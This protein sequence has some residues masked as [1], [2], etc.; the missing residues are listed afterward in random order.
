M[1]SEEHRLQE[2][3]KPETPWK[4]WGPYLSERQWGTVRE[5]YSETGDAWNYFS[6]DQAR[7]RAYRWGEDG[8]A[9]I[10]DDRQR[11]C[12]ALALWNGADPIIKERLFGL[13]N[14]EGNHGED[15]KEYYFYLDS[16]PTHSYMKYLYK[17]PQ[18]AYPYDDLVQT[19]RR[20]GRHEPEYELLDTGVFDDNR[21]FDVLVEYAKATPEDIL[22][23]LSVTNRGAEAAP[24]HLLP[25]LWFRNTWSWTADAPRPSL[26]Q[27]DGPAGVSAV[28]AS[29]T[30]GREYSF[31]CEGSVPLLF[32]ENETNTERIFH[33]A[34]RTP[35][36]KDAIDTYIVHG[37]REAVNPARTGTKVA[38]HYALTVEAG[39]TAVVRLRLTASAAAAS[40]KR[41]WP[42][43]RRDVPRARAGGGRLLR[44]HHPGHGERRRGPGHATGPGRDAVVEA[45][46]QLR[47]RRVAARAG[48]R[49]QQPAAVRDPQR[50]LGPHGQRGRHLHARQ[51]GVPV[52]RGVGP[53]LPYRRPGPRGSPLR[54]AA[55]PPHARSAVPPPERPDPRV[56]V[57]L[58]RR[59]SPRARVGRL[60]HLPPGEGP[61]RQGRPRLPP[62]GL[63]E[64]RHQLHL[65]GEPEGSER[66]QRLPGGLPRPRQHRRLRPQRTAAHRGDAGAG[67]R[68]RLDGL[69]LPVH[70]PDL[71]GAGPRR[72]GLPGPDPQVLRALPVDRLRHG[73]RRPPGRRAVGRGGRLLLRRPPPPQ[74]PRRPPE[75]PIDGGPALAVRVDRLSRRSGGALPGRSSPGPGPSWRA[76]PTWR[77][78]SRRPPAAAYKQPPPPRPAQRGQAAPGAGAHARRER[79]PEPLRHPRALAVPPRASVR[80]LRRPRGLPGRLRAG[81]VDERAV[82]RQL[83]LAGP[84]LVPGEHPAA[85]RARQ[86]LRVLRR[87]LHRGVPDR[88]GP[89]DEP[90]RGHAGA[91]APADPDLP[92]RRAG[93]PPGSRQRPQ[94]PG[95]SPLARPDPVLRVLPRRQR[96]RPRGQPPDGLDGA[97]RPRHSP[98]RL[99]GRPDAPRPLR[100]LGAGPAAAARREPAR[101]RRA[102][103]RKA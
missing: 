47:R 29:D 83:Q 78:T 82:R 59:E 101:A 80:L 45:V 37:R 51:V 97:G 28:V 8:L 43:L 66:A 84:D 76:T 32:T 90:L 23:R 19:N 24:L 64:A 92:A 1:A 81:R 77:P 16:T 49:S 79:V 34:N 85:A 93:R 35:Y 53:R 38:A 62:A 11:L 41:L 3:T 75:S 68:H 61:A 72:P 17:Y 36:V 56:R 100:P 15:V 6:H 55:A 71:V 30:E 20:R 9:G 27:L 4:K 7:S 86:P 33:T 54:Q 95:R 21:Y 73:P 102:P 44:G 96:R 91:G 98:P 58:Q 65:V 25:T 48:P 74:R 94:V 60:V 87:R 2:A 52:V 14:S 70:A 40:G 50:R 12:F 18:R 5:D 42:G 57:E 46:L 88:L 99:R 31:A 69:L 10:S 13:T 39:A 22:I 26:R 103:R 89:D 63:P 67:R